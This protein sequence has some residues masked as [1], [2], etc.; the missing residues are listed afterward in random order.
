[1]RYTEGST[2]SAAHAEI[3]FSSLVDHN[4]RVEFMEQI[5]T[6]ELVIVGSG[7]GAMTAAITARSQEIR[8]LVVEKESLLG[9]SSAI[10]GGIM[11]IPNNPVMLREGER[12]SRESALT[13]LANFT[14]DAGMSSTPARREA[15]V[16]AGPKMVAFMEELGMKFEYC[17]E[18]ADY[19]AH[20]PGGHQSGRSLQAPLFDVKKLG[21]WEAKLRV[22]PA[23]L[24]ITTLEGRHVFNALRSKSGA[25][26]AAQLGSRMAKDK[27]TGSR[28]MGA[29]AAFMGRLLQIAVDAGVEF[30]TDT[31]F[32]E[33]I[34]SDG[35]VS[36]IQASKNSQQLEI[37]AP[38]GVLV[39]TGGFARNA[40]MRDRYLPK[41]SPVEWSSASPGE[42]GE[43][44]KSMMELG[45][46]TG[47]MDT[48]WWLPTSFPPDVGG[49]VVHVHD[50][51]KPFG[52][53]VNKEGKRFA[54][55]T[56]SYM[57]I[58]A[59]M[60]DQAVIDENALA[61]Y[62]MDARHRK[63]YPWFKTPPGQI[64][65]EWL[66]SGWMKR[67]KTIEGLA[68]ECGIDPKALRASVDRYNNFARAG[69]DDDF[70]R[71]G[72]AYAHYLRDPKVKPNGSLAPIEKGPFLAVPIVPG[73]VGTAGGVFT[74]ESARV[75]T[76]EGQV[77]EG[78]YAAG[79]CTAPVCGS[80]YTG[81]GCS[82]GA[83]AVFGYIAVHHMLLS[84][85]GAEA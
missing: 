50:I 13:Y 51:A 35:R 10:S 76:E 71:G 85:S 33:F 65:K 52:I 79:N 14:Q 16:D 80:H 7:V 12:D 36:G 39:A 29:G 54:N 40:S 81:A 38:R 37:L 62:V 69:V 1:M 25:T 3:C 6:F 43:A 27:V 84:K 19:Y 55:E 53:L 82:I 41:P 60:Y 44:I 5:D 23:G 78:L 67:A 31:A 68:E 75:L 64:P 24:P 73:D 45:A 15:F 20:L 4:Q 57:E 2:F 63:Y 22:N 83:S 26:T 9:G 8:V 72:N 58:G 46:G 48:C 17:A 56:A 70:D 59:A 30:R 21:E 74:D 32:R 61:W 77:I 49:P 34:V 18:Y 66:S 47:H 42:T 28:R 11:W